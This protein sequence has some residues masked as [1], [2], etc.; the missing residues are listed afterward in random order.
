MLLV[1][2]LY[3]TG[4]GPS[5]SAARAGHQTAS[6]ERASPRVVAEDRA[7]G[8][9]AL[10]RQS[11][12][13]AEY[14]GGVRGGEEEPSSPGRLLHY[15]AITCL[16]RDLSVVARKNPA[17]VSSGDFGDN[18]DEGAP[19]GYIHIENTVTVEPT[20][21]TAKTWFSIFDRPDAPPCFGEAFRAAITS[22]GLRKSG[23]SVGKAHIAHLALPRYGAQSVAYRLTVPI[24]AE[25]HS[26]VTYLDYVLVR[27]ARVH[28]MLTFERLDRPV[29]SKLEKRVTAQT[30]RR[31]RG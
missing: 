5:S 28:M 7:L 2:L 12:F 1:V 25:G 3:M 31:L 24:V 13:P 8:E 15:T 27:K 30:A 11:D 16:H 6:T 20:V 26:Y 9:R 29:S 23:N 21:V 17:T 19:S 14:E 22:P 18:T 4:C 10:L